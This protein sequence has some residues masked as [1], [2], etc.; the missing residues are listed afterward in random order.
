MTNI[1]TEELT[2]HGALTDLHENL[3]VTALI[4]IFNYIA[5]DHCKGTVVSIEELEKSNL[6]WVLTSMNY[7]IIR[8][9]KLEEKITVITQ[10]LNITSLF[11]NRDF[12]IKDEAGNE[13]VKATSKWFLLDTIKRR[14]V[15]PLPITYKLHENLKSDSRLYDTDCERLKPLDEYQN[16]VKFT[17]HYLDIDFNYHITS[18]CYVKWI[19]NSLPFEFLEKNQI[20]IL[21]ASY[22][23]EIRNGDEVASLYSFDKENPMIT[24]HHIVANEHTSFLAK[25]HWKINKEK[26]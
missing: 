9:P 18:S 17:P 14:P 4:N 11:Y 5:F 12:L 24:H 15:K 19:I 2:I 16:S 3:K 10:F 22:V 13:I 7:N 8:L 6:S 23:K 1:Y 21:D 25:V 20:D 26:Y